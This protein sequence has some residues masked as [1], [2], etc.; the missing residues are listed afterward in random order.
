MVARERL[1]QLKEKFG[2]AIVR[3]DLPGDDRL[4]VIVEPPSVKQVCRYVFRDLDARYVISIGADDRPYS[5]Q[6]LV[7]HDFAFDRDHV[8]CSILT[9]LPAEAP[10][11]DSISDVVYLVG[12]DVT[13]PKTVRRVDPEFTDDA[14]KAHVEGTVILS[15][16]VGEDGRPRDI[17]VERKLGHGLDEAAIQAIGKWVFEPGIR[18][19]AAVPV[20]VS[21]EITFSRH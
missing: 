15:L 2:P 8:L 12:T 10:R 3:A 17:Q 18:N 4:F 11:I 9:Y 6:F 21:A 20:A 1:D 14:R 19:G 13:P 16:I 7:A 5:G